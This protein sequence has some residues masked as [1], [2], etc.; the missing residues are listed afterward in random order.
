MSNALTNN[1]SYV[2]ASGKNS[3]ASLEISDPDFL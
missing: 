2:W 3:D 1:N